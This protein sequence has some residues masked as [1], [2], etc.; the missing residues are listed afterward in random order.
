VARAALQQAVTLN[1]TAS[2]AWFALGLTCQDL[3]DETK[4]VTAYQAA[5][6]HRPDFAEAAVNLG[7]AL[8]RQGDMPAAI[9]AYRSAIRIRPDSFGR[10]AQAVTAART[11]MLWLDPAAFRRALGA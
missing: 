8:Q 3:H 11:G 7:I 10:I 9:D 4:A 2:G 1:P 5:L 6:R